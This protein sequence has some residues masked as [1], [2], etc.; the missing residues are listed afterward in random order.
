MWFT[1]YSSVC[2]LQNTGVYVVYSI[3]M[4][5]VSSIQCA[6]VVYSIQ[7]A[8]VVYR[9]HCASVVYSIQW[10]VWYTVNSGVCGLQ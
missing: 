8:S 1:V 10:C 6:S 3:V 2:G 4:S 9:I 7:C 5:V